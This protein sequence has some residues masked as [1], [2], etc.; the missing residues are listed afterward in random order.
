MRR[1]SF[2]TQPLTITSQFPFCSLPLRLDAY[3]GCSFGCSYC[4]AIRRGGNMPGSNIVA[5]DPDALERVFQYTEHGPSKLSLVSQMI[6][7][8]VPIHFGGMSDPFQPAERKWRVTRQYLKAMARRNYPVVISTKG[9]LVC[10]PEYTDLLRD[11]GHVVVQFSFSTLVDDRAIQIE[12][13]STPPSEM[14]KCMEHLSSRGV[15]VTCRWQPYIPGFSETPE[16]FVSH[17]A[18]TGARHLAFEHLK[19]PLELESSVLARRNGSVLQLTK[20][21]YNLGGAIRDGRE[22]ILPSMQK[23]GMC[24][25]VRKL[26][27]DSG[28]SFGAADNEFLALSDGEACCSGVDQFGGFENVFRYNIACAVRRG[29]GSDITYDAIADE[30]RPEGSIDRY[31][32]SHSRIGQRLSVKGSIDDHVRYRWQTLSACGGPTSF[33][34]VSSTNRISPLGLSIYKCSAL[35]DSAGKLK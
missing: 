29:R 6:V 9:A 1:K 17:I 8:R 32:N 33:F 11:I 12:P 5:A 24:L 14:L 26:T 15:T 35:D 13:N 7:R 18:A 22:Y 34:G 31:L 20:T 28:M 21:A 2:F 30:W 23:I 25:A 3:R 16:R 4:F 10:D 27:R 19:I